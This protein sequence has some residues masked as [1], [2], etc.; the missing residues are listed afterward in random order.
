MTVPLSR[1]EYDTLSAD[2]RAFLDAAWSQL[3]ASQEAQVRVLIMVVRG[4]VRHDTA[5]LHTALPGVFELQ[6]RADEAARELIAAAHEL[7]SATQSLAAQIA[8]VTAAIGRETEARTNLAARV[9]HLSV[10]QSLTT[11][12]L[13][14]VV[15]ETLARYGWIPAVIGGA[16]L[17]LVLVFMMAR[18]I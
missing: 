15:F 14:V 11:A 17:T 2:D 12:I 7:R 13:T 16:L 6:D 8:D 18:P 1:A 9:D 4:V 5:A 10:R 3:D